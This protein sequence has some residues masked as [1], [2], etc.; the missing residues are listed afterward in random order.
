MSEAGAARRRRSS[1]SASRR[2]RTDD[3]IFL[4]SAPREPHLPALRRRASARPL[5]GSSRVIKEVVA[6]VS[7]N[8]FVS[9]PYLLSLPAPELGPACS[10]ATCASPFDLAGSKAR[11]RDRHVLRDQRRRPHD[12]QDDRRANGADRLHGRD[13]PRTRAEREQ[14]VPHP[15]MQHSSLQAAAEDLRSRS[16]TSTSRST[17]GCSCA[18]RRSSIC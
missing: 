12:P 7:S 11:A 1:A 3:R 15:E 10:C 16:S 4:S 9:L 2:P 5:A 6:L 18:C 8:V 13:L 14:A 17:R